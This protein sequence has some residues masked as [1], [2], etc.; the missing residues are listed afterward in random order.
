MRLVLHVIVVIG[1]ASSVLVISG[2]SNSSTSVVVLS[3]RRREPQSVSRYGK[4]ATITRAFEVLFR[5]RFISNLDYAK[6]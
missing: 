2:P 6:K 5:L 3:R 4:I 1:L